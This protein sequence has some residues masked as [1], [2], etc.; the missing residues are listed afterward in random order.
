[1]KTINIQKIHS[2][3]VFSITA[4]TVALGFWAYAHCVYAQWHRWTGAT[5]E[6]YP[7][8]NI[9]KKAVFTFEDGQFTIYHVYG[10][11]FTAVWEE[12]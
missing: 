9:V 4:E 7:E 6:Y 12:K 3:I 8:S 10:E 1:M 5:F 2:T 11:R